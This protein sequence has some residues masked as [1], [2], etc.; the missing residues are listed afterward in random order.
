[1]ATWDG[2]YSGPDDQN[3]YVYP[4]QNVSGTTTRNWTL[5]PNNINND[6]LQ[7]NHEFYV[8]N[9]PIFEQNNPNTFYQSNTNVMSNLLTTT[10]YHDHVTNSVSN[11]EV[12][13][14]QE[15]FPNVDSQQ[16]YIYENNWNSDYDLLKNKIK[17]DSIKRI[18]KTSSNITNHSKLHV[19][20]QEFVP[21]NKEDDDRKKNNEL[22]NTKSINDSDVCIK[23]NNKKS[24]KYF[25]CNANRHEKKYNNKRSSNYKPKE[26]QQ[27][28]CYKR[29]T[30]TNSYP[31]QMKTPYKFLGNKYF[32]NKYYSGKSQ[33]NSKYVNEDA[34]DKRTMN[35]N[36]ACNSKKDSITNLS[37]RERESSLN[38][39]K[40]K[41]L[42][43]E[44]NDERSII[45]D[46]IQS[47]DISQSNNLIKE[48][49]YYNSGLKQ[50]YNNHKS[51]RKYN[52]RYNR[53][54]KL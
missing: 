50:T 41:N 12:L 46:N 36:D 23:E 35:N 29:N 47:N 21:N 39:N 38:I 33:I 53:E 52:D 20:A 19:M 25:F 17:H 13:N 15:Y 34:S 26:G 22:L 45:A 16:C 24:N 54:K 4:D 44:D 11:T 9:E 27:D 32:T 51:I 37:K 49:T 7:P 2:S 31:Q 1:M 18:K 42:S 10:T 30:N 40:N 48:L 8:Q 28:Q 5:F 43:N 3:C 6:Y 14:N